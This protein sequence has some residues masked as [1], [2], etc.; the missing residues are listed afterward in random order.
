MVHNVAWGYDLGEDVAHLTTNI[1]SLDQESDVEFRYESDFFRADE[2]VRIEDVETS[3]V[4][5]DREN[6]R[7]W[8]CL[9]ER[10]SSRP[11]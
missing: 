8:R 7:S 4:L 10:P 3:A 2:V 6:V 11:R 1:T 9:P 5:F